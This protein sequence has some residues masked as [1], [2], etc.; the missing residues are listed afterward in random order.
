MIVMINGAFGVG[1]TSVALQL[2]N[3]IPNTIIYDPEEIGFMLRNVIPHTVML[4]N[5]KT[6]DFQDLVLWKVVVVQVA[7]QLVA[8]YRCNLIVPM[9]IKN[10]EYFDY[11]FNGFRNIDQ[12]TFCFCLTASKECIHGR[13]KERG[14]ELGSWAYSQTED[15]LRAYSSDSFGE[16]IDTDNKSIKD[17]IEYIINELKGLYLEG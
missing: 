16:Y 13:L 8:R 12:N 14:D 10:K 2:V 11:I 1:K 4:E 7:Q 5:E 9:T 15:C 6:G 3:K 17:I